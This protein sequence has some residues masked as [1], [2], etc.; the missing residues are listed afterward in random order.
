M[1]RFRL[2]GLPIQLG[3]L[4]ITVGHI[5]RDKR[6]GSPVVWDLADSAKAQSRL[7]SRVVAQ[8]AWAPL[9]TEHHLPQKNGAMPCEGRH[10]VAD[11]IGWLA[12]TSI[13]YQ[14]KVS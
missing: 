2:T 11:S 6:K 9:I 8:Q 5:N 13:D 14:P 4:K 3:G 10:R 1:R 12:S 7:L